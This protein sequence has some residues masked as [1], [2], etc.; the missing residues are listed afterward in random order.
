MS[1]PLYLACSLLIIFVVS[2]EALQP[3]IWGTDVTVTQMRSDDV[4]LAVI[5]SFSQT[6]F[7]DTEAFTPCG[8][9]TYFSV[10][11]DTGKPDSKIVTAE[12]PVNYYGLEMAYIANT[13]FFITTLVR[14]LDDGTYVMNLVTFSEGSFTT[15][16]SLILSPEQF[17]V[18]DFEVNIAVDDLTATLTVTLTTQ[19]QSQEVSVLSKDQ[20]YELI[21]HEKNNYKIVFECSE[22]ETCYKKTDMD[23][24][25]VY[26]YISGGVTIQEQDSTSTLIINTKTYKFENLTITSFTSSND[27]SDM[28]YFISGTFND[29]MKTE[30]SGQE[31]QYC[32]FE[33]KQTYCS[34]SIVISESDI[35]CVLGT[36]ETLGA[37]SSRIVDQEY[38]ADGNLLYALGYFGKATNGENNYKFKFG[39]CCV[40][41]AA[42][43]TTFVLQLNATD[44][45][46]VGVQTFG[47]N[48][49]ISQTAHGQF[50]STNFKGNDAVVVGVNEINVISP[51]TKI[52]IANVT[53]LP[54]VGLNIDNTALCADSPHNSNN[55]SSDSSVSISISSSS[56][57]SVQSTADSTG[58]S[59]LSSISSG[60]NTSTSNSDESTDFGDT[61]NNSWLTV[62]LFIA[63]IFIMVGLLVG[64]LLYKKRA[65]LIPGNSNSR[66]V[67]MHR[68]SQLEE[69]FS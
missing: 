35:T 31:V 56:G 28:K 44:L 10:Y 64:Y 36:G 9:A 49:D 14:P 24:D 46:C 19:S 32:T 58:S 27:N 17:V 52:S 11:E 37:I 8:Y 42:Q 60:I 53:T 15:S 21:S 66:D 50:I 30:K 45:S 68:F 65:K 23:S 39:D 48:N 67:P 12:H 55:N 2:E 59:E 69:E 51:V 13:P 7:F 63:V 40:S 41:L 34:V 38:L 20:E 62:T 5:G 22:F 3:T 54:I 47:E 16:S 43:Y 4:S 26:A 25:K 1:L 6:T 61:S 57:S 29:N 33:K 18:N